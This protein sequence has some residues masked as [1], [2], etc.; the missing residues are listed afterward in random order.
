MALR[1]EGVEVLQ[2][3]DAKR[4]L[5]R[6]AGPANNARKW[7]LKFQI[8]GKGG[9]LFYPHHCYLNGEGVSIYHLFITKR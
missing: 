4:R 6:P 2:E 8:V 5:A 3:S 9:V 7:R 1:A